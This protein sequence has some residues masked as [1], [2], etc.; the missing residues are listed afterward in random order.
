MYCLPGLISLLS[1]HGPAHG[2]QHRLTSREAGL[3]SQPYDQLCHVTSRGAWTPGCRRLLALWQRNALDAGCRRPTG[4]IA[5]GR[6][7]R[8]HGFTVD[9]GHFFS[10]FHLPPLR[11]CYSTSMSAAAFPGLESNNPSFRGGA[12]NKT[13]RYQMESLSRTLGSWFRC[14]HPKSGGGEGS[15]EGDARS[16]C[17]PVLN[18]GTDGAPHA[19][20]T[21]RCIHY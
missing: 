10:W 1:V 14:A 19:L 6:R 12:G 4:R 8:L 13:P 20:L 11:Y 9:P 15:S 17:W 3:R 7:T 5:A 18:S 2:P 21:S 16:S